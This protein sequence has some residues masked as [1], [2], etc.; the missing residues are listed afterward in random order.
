MVQ[1]LGW[2]GW[3]K[4]NVDVLQVPKKKDADWRLEG[5]DVW[6]SVRESHCW[7][8]NPTNMEAKHGRPASA[9]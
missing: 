7:D 2:S 9:R 4:E 8:I 5:I 1:G 6:G 3:R